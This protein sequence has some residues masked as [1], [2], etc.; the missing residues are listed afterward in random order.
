MVEN[1]N[2]TLLKSDIITLGNMPFNIEYHILKEESGNNPYLIIKCDKLDLKLSWENVYNIMH[3]L[4]NMLRSDT[5][6]VQEFIYDT[7]GDLVISNIDR[8]LRIGICKNNIYRDNTLV[9]RSM[10]MED[11][12]KFMSDA[13]NF[14]ETL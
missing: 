12:K 14:M 1:I 6:R 8:C 3:T 7:N 10:D 4:I 11:V 13:L 2:N 9:F 5:I